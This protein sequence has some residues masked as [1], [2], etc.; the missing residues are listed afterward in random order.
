MAG[1]G[2]V[3]NFFL[4]HG[5]MTG[6]YNYRIYEL[7]NMRR[8]PFP[9]K[10]GATSL[11]TFLMCRRLYNENL[12]EEDT[13]KA[14]LKYRHLYDKDYTEYLEVEN[15]AGTFSLKEEA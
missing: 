4:Y 14:A 7:V 5:V 15:A 12:Y 10:L 8:V 1:Y 3:F 13:Y 6:I 9:L 11:V 2:F